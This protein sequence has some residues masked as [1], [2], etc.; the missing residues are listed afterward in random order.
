MNHRV[1]GDIKVAAITFSSEFGILGQTPGADE[2][3]RKVGAK[4]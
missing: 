3:L 1:K 2:L 4:E